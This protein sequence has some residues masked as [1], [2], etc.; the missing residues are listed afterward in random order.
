MITAKTRKVGNS[1]AVSI[2]KQLDVNFDEE[3]IIYKSKNGSIIMTPK[4]DN[5][6]KSEIPYEDSDNTVWQQMAQ[7]EI[8]NEL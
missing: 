4:M 1:V 7:E 2:P 5:P 3:F 8:E 6:F